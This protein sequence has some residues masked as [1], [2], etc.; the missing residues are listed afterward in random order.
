M[1][2]LHAVIIAISVF[3]LPSLGL[4]T[5]T[6]CAGGMGAELYVAGQPDAA[7]VDDITDDSPYYYQAPS[8]TKIGPA[9]QRERQGDT[10]S[11][12][13]HLPVY[14]GNM[15][16][17][18]TYRFINI[19]EQV[20]TVLGDGKHGLWRYQDNGTVRVYIT[21]EAEASGIGVPAP[22][23]NDFDLRNPREAQEWALTLSAADIGDSY[24]HLDK[25]AGAG[26]PGEGGFKSFAGFNPEPVNASGNVTF[27]D[28][29]IFHE[30]FHGKYDDHPPID[31]AG[32]YC[33]M[34][35]AGYPKAR[36]AM[37]FA[38]AQPAA[39]EVGPLGVRAGLD[40]KENY[41]KVL[42]LH[43]FPDAR[44]WVN[45]DS[46]HQAF[47]REIDTN[48]TNAEVY[49][50]ERPF[51]N[52]E[53]LF[54]IA[55]FDDKPVNGSHSYVRPDGPY[56]E[57]LVARGLR[58]QFKTRIIEQPR[59]ATIATEN[60]G[61]KVPNGMQ[62]VHGTRLYGVHHPG[63]ETIV[64]GSGCPSM[65]G[66]FGE[67]YY[68]AAWPTNYQEITPLCDGILIDVKLFANLDDATWRDESKN[69]A[70]NTGARNGDGTTVQPGELVKNY[71]I[72]TTV[73]PIRE[74]GHYGVITDPYLIGIGFKNPEEFISDGDEVL[75][76]PFARNQVQ[77]NPHEEG[78]GRVSNSCPNSPSHSNSGA[79]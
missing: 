77:C 72:D 48:R 61:S 18:D 22:D 36:A 65:G 37:D 75:K 58:S 42:R 50:V 32:Y 9:T 69:L 21:D 67:D 44:I 2:K 54:L 19:A 66:D 26:A 13:N 74:P 6:R 60:N 15:S 3:S 17:N 10:D 39:N 24:T 11:G 35:E 1:F 23:P 64:A 12:I 68:G 53:Y 57:H 78:M 52:E 30:F 14:H 25:S 41:T 29:P 46:T 28:L 16:T 63:T 73:Q 51:F 31:L 49:L 56:F 43:G 34:S 59:F 70:N 33:T 20:I 7:T 79:Q 27:I 8:G 47:W 4:C 55:V 62:E 40:I 76:F 5:S 38:F 71:V 45:I